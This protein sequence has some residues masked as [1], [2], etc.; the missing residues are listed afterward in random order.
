MSEQCEDWTSV[1]SLEAYLGNQ[2][3]TIDNI[4]HSSDGVGRE[5]QAHTAVDTIRAGLGAPLAPRRGGGSIWGRSVLPARTIS[6]ASHLLLSTA[7]ARLAVRHTEVMDMCVVCC[8]LCPLR[9]PSIVLAS[10][11]GSDDGTIICERR[12]AFLD[13][14]RA[15]L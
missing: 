8:I 7:I 6:K 13:G 10:Y 5:E 15:F 12:P 1:P 4:T 11:L 9:L 14:S 3:S 2:Q